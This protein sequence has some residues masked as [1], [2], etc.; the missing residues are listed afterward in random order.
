VFEI[1]PNVLYSLEDLERELG[2]A[3]TARQFVDAI[4]PAKRFKNLFWGHDLIAAIDLK[5]PLNEARSQCETTRVLRSRRNGRIPLP[6][7]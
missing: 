1:R 6:T 4:H 2:D 7:E 3:M 5:P